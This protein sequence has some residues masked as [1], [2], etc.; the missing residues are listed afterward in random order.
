MW[1]KYLQNFSRNN[2]DFMYVSCCTIFLVVY[3][4]FLLCTIASAKRLNLNL[5]FVFSA[6]FTIAEN[7]MRK[8]GLIF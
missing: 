7:K 3:V 2:T 5:F 1:M 6:D 4:C 8:L